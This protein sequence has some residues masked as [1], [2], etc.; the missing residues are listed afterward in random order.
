MYPRSGD[1]YMAP[2]TCVEYSHTGNK[3]AVGYQDNTMSILYMTVLQIYYIYI[4][5]Y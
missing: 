5:I 1:K 2:I 4:Y 3:L